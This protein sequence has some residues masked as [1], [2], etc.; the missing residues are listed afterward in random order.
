MY[1]TEPS[2]PFHHPVLFQQPHDAVEAFVDIEFVGAQ[3]EVGL[4]GLFVVGADVR[5]SVGA[6]LRWS[7]LT[8][9]C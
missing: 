2:L 9:I 6:S 4:G 7:V 8:S 3:H 1:S 5:E